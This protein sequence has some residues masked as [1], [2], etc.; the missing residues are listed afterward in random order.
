MQVSQENTFGSIL[1]MA[2]RRMG[3]KQQE[4]ANALYEK[5]TEPVSRITVNRWEN[6]LQLPSVY[7]LQHLV[8]LLGLSEKETD[9]LFRAAAQVPPIIDNLPFR[10]NPFFTGRETELEQLRTLLQETGTAAI[11]QPVSIS[12]LGGIGK[13][14]LALK[15]AHSSYPGVYRI[16][17]W[18]NAAGE[19]T[20]QASYDSIAQLLKLPE[21]NERELDRCVQAVRDWLKE[22]TGWLLIM[23]NA[24]D[25][26][27]ANS[28]LPS[29]PL[30]HILFTT[31]SQLVSDSDIAAQ[32]TVEEMGPKQGL[33]FLFRRSGVVQNKANLDAARQIVKLLGGLPL[34]LDQAGAYIRTGVSCADYLERYDEHR[35]RLLSKRRLA[36]DKSCEQTRHPDSVA[37]TFALIFQK[38]YDEYPLAADILHFCAF[39]HPDA[40]PEELFYRDES[41]KPD[42]VELD[43]AVAILQRYSLIKRNMQKQT[44]SIHRL[45]QAVTIDTTSPELRAQWREHV[46]RALNAAFPEVEFKEWKQCERLLPH[47]LVCA[48]WIEHELTLTQEVAELFHKAGF[49]LRE[50]G[51]YAEA[52]PLLVRTL[53]IREQEL[54]TEHLDT[55]ASLHSLGV[56]YRRQGKYEQ[57]ETLYLQALSIYEQH[58]G[59]EHPNTASVLNDLAAL[60]VRL[61]KYEQAEILYQRV[62]TVREQ[63]LGAE[64]LD[65]AESLH[66]LAELYR[67]QGK[68][69]QAEPLYQRV[70]SI[71]KELLGDEH[72]DIASLLHDLARL[73]DDQGK[74]EQAEALFQFALKIQEPHLGPDHPDTALSLH[75]LAALYWRQGK[76]EQAEP[77]CQRALII[78]ENQLG[79]EH[80]DTARSLNGMAMLYQQ[81]GKYEQAEV[82]WL[83]AL[84]IFE[85]QPET[86]GFYAAYPLHG[87]ARLLQDQGEHEQA[88]VLYQRALNIQDQQLRPTRL[89]S[90]ATR[91]DYAQFLRRIGRDAEA[92]AIE[93]SQS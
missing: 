2:R 19:G 64:H 87:L 18:V 13:T 4:L 85:R 33:D 52:E 74:Y 48:T 73:Y 42:T 27:L 20:L 8:T 88:E 68:Y 78:R 65:T 30:G 43:E 22:H 11:T 16:V 44:F 71:R 59:T 55:G 26:P 35:H 31:R 81:Q 37:V 47:A 70:L 56:L 58:L 38:V 77:L 32:I 41:F 76:Y 89:Y 40:I 67:R 6:D 50:R 10:P 82:L 29:Q 62:L 7:R 28:F 36:G 39:L 23:D 61:G 75:N 12:G 66:N 72:P 14:E 5:F 79:A 45:V 90:K 46:V 63:H 60:Y 21:W 69:E 15:Y 51:Q 9:A 25:L 86:E 93:S 83:Q 54:G 17:L 49:Y 57:A 24:D 34:A 91:N 92:A 1:A 3:W 80:P 53:S 84:A